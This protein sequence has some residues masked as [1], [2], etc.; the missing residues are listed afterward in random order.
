MPNQKVILDK[1]KFLYKCVFNRPKTNSI[2]FTMLS[3]LS[4]FIAE[5]SKNQKPLLFS[6]QIKNQ[7][8]SGVD[9][10]ELVSNQQSIIDLHQEAY[11]LLF[12]MQTE[13]KESIS[14][15]DGNMQGLGA[16]L[17]SNCKYRVCTDSS[18]WS[19]PQHFLGLVPNLGATYY[20]SKIDKAWGLY[21][22]L[23]CAVLESFDPYKAGLATHYVKHQDLPQLFEALDT[24]RSISDVL[25]KFH[26]EPTGYSEY[27]KYNDHVQKVFEDPQS[28]EEIMQELYILACHDNNFSK[29]TR[30]TLKCLCPLTLKVALEKF[31][32]MQTTSFEKVLEDEALLDARILSSYSQNVVNGV[33]QRVI[34][35]HHKNRPHWVPETIGEVTQEMVNDLL[36]PGFKV[37]N[38]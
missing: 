19:M 35:R 27:S 4:D 29:R 6:S 33:R 16:S 21:L 11:T 1:G 30:D 7:F 20:L 28:M 38:L 37:L 23:T 15:W 12:K 10:E 9:Y 32:H 31:K 3:Q 17:A 34:H 25:E 36:K 2:N 8:S 26:C 5:A 13:V 14:I 22:Y 24:T 18:A